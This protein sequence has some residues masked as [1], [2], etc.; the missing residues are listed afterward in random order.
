MK[1]S[2]LLTEGGSMLKIEVFGALRNFVGLFTLLAGIFIC[3]ADLKAEQAKWTFM[4]YLDGDNNLEESGIDDFLEMSSAGSNSDV[5]IVVQM[6]RIPGFD[7]RYGDWTDT[8]RFLVTSGMTPD[9][10]NAVED[11]GEANM[12]DGATL[13][14]FIDWASTNYPADNY[15]LVLWNHGGGWRDRLNKKLT[16]AI[17]WDDTDGGDC[18][19]VKEMHNAINTASTDMTL[20]GMDACLMAMIEVAYEIRDT[21]ISVLVTSEKTEPGAGWP[22]NTVME[23]LLASPTMTAAEFGTAI[24]D[25]YYESYGNDETQSAID[26]AQISNLASAVNLLSNTIISSWDTDQTAVQTAAGDVLTALQ[27][28]VINEKHGA[29][30]NGASGLTI[31]FPVSG[32]DLNYTANNIDFAGNTSWPDFLAEFSNS[33]GDSW[34]AISRTMAISF[35]G[36]PY[37]DIGDFCDKLIN[38]QPP[39]SGYDEAV[40]AHAFDNAGTAQ[41]WKAD[42]ASWT[43]E[44]PF[45]FT[46]YG[47]E[48]DSLNVCSNGFVDFASTSVSYQNSDLALIQNV[49][50]AALW[51]DLDT[52]NG[53]I[54]IYQPSADSLC[55]RWAAQDINTAL[56][57]NVELILYQDGRIQ[58]N[59]GEE[60]TSLTPTIG[61]SSGDGSYYDLATYDNDST[62]TNAGSL[63][64]TPK[65]LSTVN[66]TMEVLPLGAGATVPEGSFTKIQGANFDISAVPAVGYAFTEWTGDCDGTLTFADEYSAVT[67]ANADQDASITANF[68]AVPTTVLTIAADPEE[69]IGSVYWHNYNSSET[70]DSLGTL[71]FN[72]GDLLSFWVTPAPGYTFLDF[73]VAGATVE[74]V[75][76]DPPW[77]GVEVRLDEPTA[78]ITANFEETLPCELTIAATPEEAIDSVSW[79]NYNSS[80]TGDSLG[81]FTFNTGDMVYVYFTSAPGY[82][83]VDFTVAGATVGWS[84]YAWAE[85]TLDEPTASISANFEAV[86]T[87][88]LTIAVNP[89]EATGSVYWE[90]YNSSEIGDS[91]GT[92]TF[93]TGD[94]VY[95]EFQPAIGYAFMDFTVVGA[96]VGWSNYARAQIILDE[97]K[98]SIT[99]NF[100]ETVPCELTVAA[101]PEEAI[102]SV[103]WYNYNSSETGDSLG[104]FTF[105]TGDLLSFLV[106][107]APGY[108]FVDF[109]VAGAT[110]ES[111]SFDPP[112]R[113][114]LV[115]LDEPTASITAN[116]EET[117]PCE[118]TIAAAPE[119]AID[120]VSWKNYNSSET[121]DSLGTFTFNTGDLV[122]VDFTPATGYVFVDFTVVGATVGWG[123]YTWAEIT[124]DEP[125]ASITANFM[126][127]VPAQLTVAV[128]PF[129]EGNYLLSSYDKVST[130]NPNPSFSNGDSLLFTPD[131]ANYAETI[132]GNDFN[133]A[134][135]AQGWKSDDE[136]WQYELPFVFSF[137]GNDYSTVNVCSNGYLDF[138]SA[139]PECNNSDEGLKKNVRIAPFWKDLDTTDGDIY[140]HQPTSESLCVRWQAATY[141]GA[142][143][144]NFEVVLYQD[145][146]IMFNYGEVTLDD[147]GPT[148]GL[149]DGNT[150]FPG[151]VFWST[152]SHEGGL[153]TFEVTTGL[154]NLE[155]TSDDDRY[156]F[157][158]W[159][160]QGFGLVNNPE[161]MITDG[162]V[163]GDVAITAMYELKPMSELTI[164]AAP[165]EAIGSVY[166]YNYNSSETGDSLGT[167]TFSTGDEIYVKV[168]SAEAYALTG[169]T[170]EGAEKSDENIDVSEGD[171]SFFLTEPTASVTANFA[172]MPIVTVATNIEEAGITDPEPGDYTVVPG[173]EFIVE[174]YPEDGYY[175][176]EWAVEGDYVLSYQDSATIDF[177]V[178]G[179][180]QVTANFAAVA[181]SQLLL[182]SEPA[183]GYS[184]FDWTNNTSTETGSEPGTYTVSTGDEMTLY[185]EP[186]ENYYLVDFCVEGVTIASYDES[187][188]DFTVVSDI[189]SVTANFSPMPLVTVY[190]NL[191]EG[192][193]IAPDAGDYYV[194]Y[195][196]EFVVEATP[197]TGYYMGGWTIE[198]DYILNYQDST[199]ID[200][201]VYG[202]TE[203]MV[204]FE[205][206]EDV[207]MT[208]A[209][210]PVEGGD[211]EWTTEDGNAGNLGTF[212]VGTG[213]I[214]V[215]PLPVEGYF[216]T[217]LAVT[218]DAS[219]EFN[220]MDYVGTISGSATI[221][222]NFSTEPSGLLIAVN[223]VRKLTNLDGTA[224]FFAEDAE[225][226]DTGLYTSDG[227]PEGTAL[228]VNVFDD[229]NPDMVSVKK[230]RKL[231]NAK[232]MPVVGDELFFSGSF[233]GTSFSLMKSD[234]TQEGTVVVK[235]DLEVFSEMIKVGDLLYMN[236]MDNSTGMQG[237]WMTD[238]TTEG[239]T[240]VREDMVIGDGS[241]NGFASIGDSVYFYALDDN[242]GEEGLWTSD[243]LTT[244]LVKSLAIQGALIAY[245]DMLVFNGDDSVIRG[246][247]TSD[248][249][250]EGTRILMPFL[251]MG[252]MSGNYVVSAELDGLLYFPA[253]DEEVAIPALW[254]TDGTTDGTSRVKGIDIT[255]EMITLDSQICFNGS[256]LVTGNNGLYRTDGTE[257][258]TVLVKVMSIGDASAT[259]NRF[260]DADGVLCFP[261]ADSNSGIQG[262][263]TSDGTNQ[264]TVLAKP[265]M[266]IDNQMLA[267]GSSVFYGATDD[268]NDIS[269]LWFFDAVSN[270]I[271]T[272]SAGENGA[273]TPSGEVTVNHGAD[274]E[275]TITPD[276]NY[277][278]EDVL[279]DDVSVG[280]V[281]TYKFPNVTT[282]HTIAASFAINTYMLTVTGGT[283]SGSYASGTTANITADP[284]LAGKI[285]D[286][287]TGTVD[288]VADI[289]AASTTLVMPAANIIVNATYKDLPVTKYVLT[290]SGGSGTGS[291]EP[292]EV[293]SIA[294]DLPAIGKIFDKW[295]GADDT[296][297]DLYSAT[298]TLTMP[299]ADIAVTATYA[300]A[301]AN[302]LF[303]S[304]DGSDISGDGSQS[305]PYATV[306]K[307]IESATGGY[308]IYIGVGTFTEYGV[309]VDKNLTIR[310]AGKDSTIVQAHA[311]K[312]MAGDRVFRVLETF[313]TSFKNLTIRHGVSGSDGGGGILFAGTA[314]T[315]RNCI[316][317]D[318]QAE[319]GG[320]GGGIRSDGA[321]GIF[322]DCIFIGNTT[323]NGNGGGVIGG[324]T[325]TNCTITGNTADL[326]SGGG[327]YGG[328]GV[329][330]GGTFANCT[331]SNNSAYSWG[332]GVGVAADSMLFTNC[333]I[334]GNTA[335]GGGGVHGAGVSDFTD[336]TISNNG[337]NQGGGVLLANTFTNCTITGNS[338]VY[339]GGGVDAGN[340]FT[341]CTISGNTATN[342]DSYGGG[343]GSGGIFTNCTIT[344]NTATTGG[345]AWEGLSFTN[346][347]VRNCYELTFT[348]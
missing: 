93:D 164:A 201:F 303:V 341:Y 284:P 10:A 338:A 181:P 249:T 11:L 128:S 298:T 339:G 138:A 302:S 35:D 157:L 139:S 5:N 90:N 160:V 3:A 323:D 251:E 168:I 232:S 140:I 207:E 215:T 219:L 77:R 80:E 289:T 299:S 48:Y 255:A 178:F 208:I 171:V 141:S 162:L 188:I 85:I 37:V 21:G 218:G 65:A 86:P 135:T 203:V 220:G 233:D 60:N 202:D 23:D 143:P 332:G 108:A 253:L 179:D 52:S 210:D 235:E 329:N 145:G 343:C 25:R 287:W 87:T 155:T 196:E 271:I 83:F 100:E 129:E 189:A 258:G 347:T 266:T 113:G 153:G 40:E 27:S 33:M 262:L 32:P 116:F 173:E 318:N 236:A 330:N 144:A 109:T 71:T 309:T 154:I 296:L 152:D 130:L 132:E 118:L 120:S 151:D 315:V 38:Y 238:G 75:G 264:S 195:G 56:P 28:A 96:T 333:T 223:N 12:G 46:F 230:S 49:R 300:D 226:G 272:A 17:C 30:Y 282:N 149:S 200:F 216:C 159:D 342:I 304:T 268:L 74:S 307:A 67:T 209:A 295:T 95:V 166:W 103:S 206:V 8:K 73:T 119:E 247:W 182:S 175:L 192:G 111:V 274:Q 291:Y 276:A 84:G 158:G 39:Q 336:C 136:S 106:T 290:V 72:T 211:L 273:I 147:M 169:F 58:L 194:G 320:G 198:G 256:D 334:I 107:P 263:W 325:F 246:I 26:I 348:I 241:I 186:A 174:A 115:R 191:A 9:S 197:E 177:F 14:D 243:G 283:G 279:V 187:S 104:T 285:F 204:C 50:I 337:S 94:M 148:I 176:A 101:A 311:E 248:G 69:A 314:L 346:C 13:T 66:I 294:A 184:V 265:G 270:L 278:V 227:T 193:I 317:Q 45:T 89:E 156:V 221:T 125:T 63:L 225:T 214:T 142:L 231:M 36:L 301:E 122:Y 68:Q 319:G 313:E 286:R 250:A 277:H 105:N 288:T 180:T 47:T 15:A 123:D 297:S 54:Y 308:T 224:A 165:E 240:A 292:N 252:E 267:I 34:V 222:A 55:F 259:S 137:Y 20:L 41:G 53:D 183:D 344:E 43:Y 281:L 146:N 70:G 62:L 306:R 234:G 163:E 316:V 228:V 76:F 19:Y 131:L 237:L 78:S 44:L 190:A 293:V 97:A 345:G 127:S 269:G 64:F 229:G 328:A 185:V 2:I 29:A 51:Q 121:G 133:D 170:V 88:D 99:A 261:G 167:F 161:E 126:Q 22:Y 110:V 324:G 239:T 42:D 312:G 245:S 331:I 327:V 280:A 81:T 92:F 254:C 321:E 172:V 79:E 112:W 6:D 275:F 212:T 7:N 1:V 4:V 326:G 260:T 205:P 57:V 322:A 16:K 59:Y 150:L 124:L 102:G 305:N 117:V 213:G 61:L 335:D 134:G 340:Y 18:L 91:L 257:E 242:S 114:V 217:G 24:V 244:T 31:N 310:G 98:A 199:I 82:A